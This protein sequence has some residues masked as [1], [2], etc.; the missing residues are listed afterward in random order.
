KQQVLA[1]VFLAALTEETVAARS[2]VGGHNA[3]ADA[4]IP[5]SDFG[6][7]TSDFA[8]DTCEFVAKDRGRHDHPGVI[9][10]FEHLQVGA[11]SQRGLNINPH[12]T[13]LKRAGSDLLDPDQFFAM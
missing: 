7:G 1:E 3:I 11:T 2:R 12:F 10:A 9:A 6:L 13:G 4:P 8:D 5:I